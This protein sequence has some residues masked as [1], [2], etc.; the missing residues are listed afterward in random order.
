MKKIIIA[1]FMLCAGLNAGAQ[2]VYNEVLRMAK[3]AAE[4]ESKDMNI[5]LNNTFKYDALKYMMQKTYEEMPDSS[6]QVLDY[7]ALA[8]YEFVALYEEKLVRATRGDERKNV[9]HRFKNA[10]LYNS[11]F[12]DRDKSLVEAYIGKDRYL[13]QFSLDTDWVK[14][15]AEIKRYYRYY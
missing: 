5:R 9:I 11:R 8:L 6:A 4:N 7:Q 1:L 10:S 12:N 13:T 14:A 15:L 3:E 2:E